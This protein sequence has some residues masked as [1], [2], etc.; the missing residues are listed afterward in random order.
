MGQFAWDKTPAEDVPEWDKPAAPARAASSPSG[1]GI[2][3]ATPTA[4]QMAEVEANNNADLLQLAKAKEKDAE[5]IKAK[6]EQAIKDKD[7]LA[8]AENSE[9]LGGLNREIKAGGGTPVPV[10][11]ITQESPLPQAA[12]SAPGGTGGEK[13]KKGSLD[14]GGSM[15]DAI[16]PDNER[17]L[18]AALGGGAGAFL[19]AAKGP[20][21]DSYIAFRNKVKNLANPNESTNTNKS[22]QWGNTSKQSEAGHNESAHQKAVR[23]AEQQKIYTGA[24]L[25]P[26]AKVASSPDVGAT[27]E[28]LIIDKATQAQLD[29]EKAAQAQAANQSTWQKLMAKAEEFQKSPDPSYKKIGV[30]LKNQ[31]INMWNNGLFEKD[32]F[33]GRGGAAGFGA[34][35][36]IPNAIENAKKGDTLGAAQNIGTGGALGWAMSH[37]P[38]RVALPLNSGLQAVDAAVRANKGDYLGAGLSTFGAAAPYIV[39]F[40]LAPELAIPAAIMAGAGPVVIN[41][42]RDWVNSQPASAPQQGALPVQAGR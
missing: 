5:A 22:T 20:I 31:A 26:N 29:A 1:G 28:G 12:A 4:A 7:I 14:F 39:P 17:L 41:T 6:L 36:A 27:R 33:I 37:I 8:I 18:D 32:N 13:D 2:R 10:P 21:V 11:S 42:V 9:L 24:G 15:F 25:D 3:R 34:G 38:Q 23:A 40:V 16:S 35:L 19:G 30:A